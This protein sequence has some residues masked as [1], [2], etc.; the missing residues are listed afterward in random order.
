YTSRPGIVWPG[1]PHAAGAAMLAMH[2]QLERSQWWTAERLVEQQFRQLRA[3]ATHALAHAP[4]YRE[5]LLRAGLRDAVQLDPASYRR[6][7]L[8]RRSD[9]QNSAAALAAA[10]LP[11]EHGAV[12]EAFTSGSTGTPVRVLVSDVGLF[13][14]HALALREHLWQQR[15]F[16]AKFAAIRFFARESRQPG[17]SPVT[18]A[19]FATGESAVMDVRTDVA[20]QLEWLIWERPAYLLTSP[21]NLRALIAHSV[22]AGRK[23]RGLRE[24]MT[25]AEAFPDGLREEA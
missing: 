12:S 18:N 11:R 9:V 14:A 16:S 19:V 1:M 23:P 2:Q 15:D 6:W 25:Y 17:W 22:A 5:H 21:S 4:Y 13:F 10:A 24:V 3:L 7:P 20:A 8:L